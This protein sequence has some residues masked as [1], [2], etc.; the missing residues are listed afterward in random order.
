M[1]DWFGDTDPRAM[2]VYI[3]CMRRMTPGEKVAAVFSLFRM[4]QQLAEG[5]V[6]KLYPGASDREVFLRAAA[7]R[8]DAETM[9][10]VYGWREG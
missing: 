1:G 6:R 3:E 5:N 7:R 2:E 10:R 8:L 4:A 9:E